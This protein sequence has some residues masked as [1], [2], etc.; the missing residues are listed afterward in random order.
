MHINSNQHPDGGFSFRTDIVGKPNPE[1]LRYLSLGR[2]W[3]WAASSGCDAA[4]YFRV[5]NPTLQQ[6]KFDKNLIYIKKWVKEF[7]T[8]EYPKPIVDHVFARERVLS[9]FKKALA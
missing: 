2:G 8:S 6:E 5:F 3:Q 4:P 7:G 9:V 1:S